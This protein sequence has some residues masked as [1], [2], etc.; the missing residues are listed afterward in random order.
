[1][2]P[3]TIEEKENLLVDK[4]KEVISDHTIDPKKFTVGEYLK[5]RKHLRNE[6]EFLF[7]ALHAMNNC[8]NLLED[9]GVEVTIPL[10]ILKDTVERIKRER[11]ES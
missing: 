4:L 2:R 6:Q 1:M 9:R 8:I 10:K 11:E 5:M 3:L 7:D